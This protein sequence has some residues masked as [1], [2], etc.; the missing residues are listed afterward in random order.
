MF[1]NLRNALFQKDITIKQY[2]EFLG[3]NT[4]TVQN[5]L[6]GETDFTY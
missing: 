3:V 5:K 6:N 2:A 1:K 4:K